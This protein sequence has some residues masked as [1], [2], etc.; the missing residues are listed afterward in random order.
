MNAEQDPHMSDP[1][2]ARLRAALDEVATAPV[3]AHASAPSDERPVAAMSGRRWL[4]V[5][6]SVVLVGA[7]VT[8]I[9]VNLSH[10]QS[11]SPAAGG[12]DST[13]PGSGS[14]A[15][16]EPTMPYFLAAADLAPGEVKTIVGRPP[17][18]AVVMAWMRGGTPS[19]GL[20]TLKATP[21]ESTPAISSNQDLTQ[22]FEDG[23][24]LEFR[25]NGLTAAQRETLVQQVIPGSGVPWLLPVDGWAMVAM[26]SDAD[27]PMLQQDFGDPAVTM[28]SGPLVS[29][30]LD[31]FIGAEEII[32]VTVAGNYGWY[33]VVDGTT[34]VMWRDPETGQW[35]A[36]SIPPDFA[37]RVDGLIAAIVPT[38]PDGTEPS[39]STVP[40][41]TSWTAD[42][43]LETAAA[44]YA[45]PTYDAGAAFDSAVGQ[46][47]PTIR[48]VD[49]TTLTV[50][51]PSLFVFVADWCP[52][53][54]TEL[55][56]IAAAVADGTL[57]GV[58]VVV[59]ATGSDSTRAQWEA[60]L[61][62]KG[63]T[64]DVVFD[65]FSGERTPGVMAGYFG[66][67]GYPYLVAVNADGT[68]AGRR[69]GEQSLDDLTTLA[70]TAA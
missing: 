7:A 58:R 43:A 25:S 5:A 32:D 18:N 41:P 20:L 22:R 35:S 1:I 46:P 4:A 16:T 15:S 27:G 57:D 63:W 50:D 37:D 30:F 53:C 3:P 44:S 6:A 67:P 38:S 64:G 66:I 28:Y 8:A 17:A 21:T 47:M 11:V 60:W 69:V 9:A 55:P 19:D 62:E 2:V 48:L 36:L 40:A 14:S 45:L 29:T 56:G 52:H 54:N 10:R 49:G 24:M 33:V 70:R 61:A 23:W 31:N 26:F 12:T 59:V 34:I 42:V 51:T 65:T 13:V 39:A 68:V